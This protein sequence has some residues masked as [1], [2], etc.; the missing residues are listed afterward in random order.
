MTSTPPPSLPPGVDHPRVRALPVET[1]HLTFNSTQRLHRAGIRTVGQVID[2]ERRG[3]L[4]ATGGLGARTFQQIR[5]GL[6]RLA[7]QAAALGPDG[8]GILD[9]RIP[10]I[11]PETP[12]PPNLV[13]W[14]PHMLRVVGHGKDRPLDVLLRHKALE[15][16]RAEILD[17]IAATYGITRERT[18]QLEAQVMVWA[19]RLLRGLDGRT[20][21]L[22]P[23]LREEVAALTYALTS[24]GPVLSAE[25]AAAIFAERYGAAGRTDSAARDF[26]LEA[27]GWER[28][29]SPAGEAFWTRGVGRDER[30]RLRRMSPWRR[31]RIIEAATAAPVGQA[32]TSIV[33][34]RRPRGGKACQGWLR[35]HIPGEAEPLRWSCKICGDAGILEDWSCSQWDLGG[36]GAV[37]RHEPLAPLRVPLEVHETLDVRDWEDLELLQAIRGATPVGEEVE[38]LLTRSALDRLIQD[39]RERR[40]D[41]SRTA[42]AR[43]DRAAAVLRAKAKAWR[44]R[45]ADR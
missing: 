5:E 6:E 17:E 15:G 16:R 39:V 20:Y 32:R 44:V 12:A 29:N 8:E 38:L 33:R 11:P 40:R 26:V 30:S 28:L 41:R 4:E 36:P 14:L 2:L 43:L 9:A 22:P 21:W 10:A 42:R 34:C 25:R 19:E 45:R 13:E 7:A 1:L 35:V 18:R 27:M 3:A 31:G 37:E 23:V 24:G